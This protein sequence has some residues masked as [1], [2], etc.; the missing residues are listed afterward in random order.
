MIVNML[1]L[2]NN[3]INYVLQF[4]TILQLKSEFQNKIKFS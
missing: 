2:I 1:H 4:K 3:A